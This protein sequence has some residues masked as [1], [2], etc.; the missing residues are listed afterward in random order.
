MFYLQLKQKCPLLKKHQHESSTKIR[1]TS[2]GLWKNC[3]QVIHEDAS[4]RLTERERENQDISREVKYFLL[5]QTHTS[6]STGNSPFPSEILYMFPQQRKPFIAN[7][8]NQF[9]WRERFWTLQILSFQQTTHR[10]NFHGQTS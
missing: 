4:N 9:P 7:G 10:H 6:Y 8:P 2:R 1:E 5:S 3:H